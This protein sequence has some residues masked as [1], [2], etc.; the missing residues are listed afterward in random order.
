MVKLLT[1]IVLRFSWRVGE[2]T[3]RNGNIATSSRE[4][5]GK[6]IPGPSIV[7]DKLSDDQ[8]AAAAAK[9]ANI[10]TDITGVS[11]QVDEVPVV[12]IN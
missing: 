5:E 3:F 9:N 10:I 11:T 6:I 4:I 2:N 8:S 1:G 12:Y 7:E